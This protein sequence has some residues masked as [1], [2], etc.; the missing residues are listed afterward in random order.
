MITVNGNN[1]NND[2]NDNDHNNDN[3]EDSID[4]DS[5]SKDNIFICILM[6]VKSMGVEIIPHFKIFRNDSKK[7]K[8]TPKLGNIKNLQNYQEQICSVQYFNDAST[9]SA[10]NVRKCPNLRS[11]SKI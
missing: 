6:Y 8:L 10:K 9:F 7:L 2:S 1:D 3:N 4:N 5:D 11:I